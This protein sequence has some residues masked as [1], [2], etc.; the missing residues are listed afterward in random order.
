MTEN[1]FNVHCYHRPEA[2][3]PPKPT[4]PNPPRGPPTLR[5][6]QILVEWLVVFRSGTTS[7]GDL[8]A[9]TYG[10]F[11]RDGEHDE[12]DVKI[13]SRTG[14]SFSGFSQVLYPDEDNQGFLNLRNSRLVSSSMGGFLLLHI[15]NQRPVIVWIGRLR[16]AITSDNC[17]RRHENTSHKPV[18]L[19]GKRRVHRHPRSQ[20]KPTVGRRP[21][22]V[23]DVLVGF[24]FKLCLARS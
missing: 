6:S 3:P 14:F 1:G 22:S 7:E 17:L 23:L 4:R 10:D 5:R 19:F 9:F 16:A 8:V 20:L 15:A 18:G 24:F 12:S 13:F 11:A 2:P 21:Y